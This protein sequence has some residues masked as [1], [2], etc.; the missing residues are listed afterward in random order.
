MSDNSTTYTG[1]NFAN[2]RK[3]LYIIF[4]GVNG[5][6][7]F[8]SENY[9]YVIPLQ[10][11]WENPLNTADAKDTYVQF[12]IEK[13]EE[14]TQDDF[15]YSDDGYK[16]FNRQ[17]RI[18]DVLLRFIGKE[19]EAWSK[20]FYHMNKQSDLGAMW[21]GVCN[22]EKLLY[23]APCY[24]RRIDYF[25]KNTSIAFDVRFRLQY[26]EFIALNWVPL[27]GINISVKSDIKVA[28]EISQ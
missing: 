21:S 16:G 15:V 26:D 18:A 8:D 24:P 11:S 10:A 28:G 14:L 5:S 1:V 9:K 4:F 7:T 12:W 17:K 25:G 19:A 13:D 6:E 3:A 20:V 2:L 27:T 22:A 23:T